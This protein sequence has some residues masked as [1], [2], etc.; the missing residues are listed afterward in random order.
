MIFEVLAQTAARSVP[1]VGPLGP[2]R[3]SPEPADPSRARGGPEKR[4]PRESAV[5]HFGSRA[6]RLA[7]EASHPPHAES[8]SAPS[9]DAELSS[10]QQRQIGEMKRRDR[11]VRT[12]E[13]AHKVAGGQHA[14]PI[15]LEYAVGPDGKRY[16]VGGSVPIDVSPVGGDPEATLRKM[17]VVRR[18]ATAP[19]SPSGADRR[20]AAHASQVA[21]RA[22]SQIAAERY[23]QSQE[24]ITDPS[25][26]DGEG[27]SF[28]ISTSSGPE[29]RGEDQSA[30]PGLGSSLQSYVL[31][32][33]RAGFGHYRSTAHGEASQSIGAS[34]GLIA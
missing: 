34:L 24:L 18:A 20:A 22:R 16:A 4:T 9:P 6:K 12:H 10:E 2:R 11:E 31:E 8:A 32:R 7:L 28:P 14:G 1:R 26:K 17:E 23:E 27:A 33:A 19:A 25:Q 5:L 15:H 30:K 29:S 21:Q 13:Q 3:D